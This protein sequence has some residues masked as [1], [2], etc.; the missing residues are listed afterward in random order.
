VKRDRD[1]RE[2]ERER[3]EGKVTNAAHPTSYILE[4]K[5]LPGVPLAPFQTVFD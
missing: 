5:R 3:D 1:E 4:N 2:R